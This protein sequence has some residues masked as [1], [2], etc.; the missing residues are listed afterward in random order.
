MKYK[1]AD[2]NAM[3]DEVKQ[4]ELNKRAKNARW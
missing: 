4:A 2:W 3:S 1:V